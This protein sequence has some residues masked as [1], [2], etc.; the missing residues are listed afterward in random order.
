MRIGEFGEAGQARLKQARVCICGA[1]GLGSPVAIYLA[2]AGVGAI[3]IVD[4]D[5]VAL[6]NLNR[7]VLHGEADIGRL[8]VD[9]AKATLNQ[10]NAHVIVDAVRSD[11]TDENAPA[12]VTRS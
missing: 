1:G 6:S 2:A 12:L 9:S 7:Q 3:T 8:K 10:L 5:R 4:H 11:I